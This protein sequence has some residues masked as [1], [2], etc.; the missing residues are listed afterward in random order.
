[1][2]KLTYAQRKR[3]PS[4]DFV[5][6]AKREFPIEDRSHARA[7][8]QMAHGARSGKPQSGARI[9]E[10]DAK[11]HAKYPGIGE[12]KKTGSLRKAAMAGRR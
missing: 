1:M 2:A 12:K 7:A 6:P 5:F 3:L 11:V 9:A 8:L 4:S 10:I